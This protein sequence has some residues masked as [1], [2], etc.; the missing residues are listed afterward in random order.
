M[1]YDFGK[2]AD[3]TTNELS[4]D[5]EKLGIL[6]DEQ[7]KEALPVRTDQEKLKQLIDGVNSAA[8]EQTKRAI[9]TERLG[10]FSEVARNAILLAVKAAV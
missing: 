1:A 7:I 5:I 2:E 6:T 4:V 10:D 8:D 3:E 9:L